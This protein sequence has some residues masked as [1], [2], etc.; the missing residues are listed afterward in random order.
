MI[1]LIHDTAMKQQNPK[2]I[3]VVF[4]KTT[5]GKEPVR[6]WMLKLG[7]DD[8]KREVNKGN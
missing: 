4:Y 2:I 6:E 1:R 5:V 3:K 8:R 7:R